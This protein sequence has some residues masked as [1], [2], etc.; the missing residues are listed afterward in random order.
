MQAKANT[1]MA[2]QRN[3]ATVAWMQDPTIDITVPIVYEGDQPPGNPRVTFE[4]KTSYVIEDAV[5]MKLY[6]GASGGNY[7]AWDG[8]NNKWKFNQYNNMGFD[9]VNAICNEVSAASLAK[10]RQ[11]SHRNKHGRS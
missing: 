11:K 2:D 7:C 8:T 5:T 1:W 4:D 9:Y 10:F 6:N 3:Q